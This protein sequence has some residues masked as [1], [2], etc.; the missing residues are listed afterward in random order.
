MRRRA[1]H[2]KDAIQIIADF[3]KEILKKERTEEVLYAE[4]RMMN[5][6]IRPLSGDVSSVNLKDKSFIQALWNLG[7]LDEFFHRY[8][9]TLTAGQR[10]IFFDVFDN[11]HER[12]EHE[13]NKLNLIEDK[14]NAPQDVEMEIFKEY[15]AKKKFN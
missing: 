7:K 3:Q 13:L 15:P 2:G 4:V 8:Y 11:L 1:D 10:K 5:F 9:H 6:K 14:G 12:F